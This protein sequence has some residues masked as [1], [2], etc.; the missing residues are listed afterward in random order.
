MRAAWLCGNRL[1]LLICS[2]IGCG[3]ESAIWLIDVLS[4]MESLSKGLKEAGLVD[5]RSEAS[6]GGSV[7]T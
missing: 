4:V 1:V 3:L 2:L 6:C 7:E 5:V